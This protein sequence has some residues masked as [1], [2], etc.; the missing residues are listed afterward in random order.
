M[1]NTNL[2]PTR[3]ISW[4]QIVLE[5]DDD[6]YARKL[7]PLQYRFSNGRTFYASNPAYPPYTGYLLDDTNTPIVGDDQFPISV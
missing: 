2:P 5:A 7:R 4:Q 3:L 6:W 1:P